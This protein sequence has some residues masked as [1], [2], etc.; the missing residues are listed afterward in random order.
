MFKNKTSVFIAIWALAKV[1]PV[2]HLT[3]SFEDKTKVTH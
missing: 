1:P 3:H 2:C